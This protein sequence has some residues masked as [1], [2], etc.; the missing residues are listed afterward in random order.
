VLPDSISLLVQAERFARA[1]SHLPYIDTVD[2]IEQLSSQRVLTSKWIEGSSPNELLDQV[3]GL[4]PGL[5]E[6]AALKA[7]LVRMVNL[8]VECSL[9]QL[10]ETGVMHADPHPGN[11]ILTPADQLAYLDFGLLTFVPPKSSQVRLPCTSMCCYC[12][13]CVLCVHSCCECPCTDA[14]RLCLCNRSFAANS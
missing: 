8:G 12:V 6:H 7:R 5:P 10:L 11:L 4:S 14:L 2:I 1:H 3:E 13:L 9:S